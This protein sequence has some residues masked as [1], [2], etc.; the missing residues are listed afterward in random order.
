MLGLPDVP[1]IDE[2]AIVQT[3]L[4]DL[5]INFAKARIPSSGTLQVPRVTSTAIPNVQINHISYIESDLWRD[6]IKFW[7]NLAL[8]YGYD[9]IEKRML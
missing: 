2:A 9:W 3:T 7:D 1:L 8:K 6:R 4:A 5:L